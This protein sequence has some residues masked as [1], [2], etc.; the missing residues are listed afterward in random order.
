LSG[1]G[2]PVFS[3]EGDRVSIV[4]D[5]F[6]PEIA[7]LDFV[8]EP[9]NVVI[10]SSATDRFHS[11]AAMVPGDPKVLSAAEI[12]SCGPVK[13]HGVKFEACPTMESLRH[14]ESPDENAIY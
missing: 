9:V 6:T 8:E 2:T 13:V 7:G 5:P 14:K 4:T 3:I 1:T 11:N 10:M 12:A